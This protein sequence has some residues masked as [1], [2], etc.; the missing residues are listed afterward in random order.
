M[1]NPENCSLQSIYPNGYGEKSH[2]K[3]RYGAPGR[4]GPCQEKITLTRC[5][6]LC[7]E[8]GE[9]FTD[10]VK[11]EK[12]MEEVEKMSREKSGDELNSKCHIN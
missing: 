2:H 3:K 1:E 7:T 12:L 10:E 6:W 4:A 8:T 11:D 5:Y 9:Q